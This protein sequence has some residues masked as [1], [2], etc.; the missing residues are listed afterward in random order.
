MHRYSIK[1]HQG[2]S[3]K[4]PCGSWEQAVKSLV[5]GLRIMAE[6]VSSGD[7]QPGPWCFWK[8]SIYWKLVTFIGV[9]GSPGY[10]WLHCSISVERI[11]Y[12]E[13][14]TLLSNDRVSRLYVVVERLTSVGQNLS[15]YPRRL[16]TRWAW[17]PMRPYSAWISL[18][19]RNC[20]TSFPCIWRCAGPEKMS[21]F[22][23][24]LQ[25]C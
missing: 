8:F 17:K 9:S 19:S 21:W 23:L 18:T 25:I 1:K 7:R 13:L 2:N 4:N 15:D 22:M 12:A 10:P 5:P 20:K 11:A 16:W 3:K 14:H 6:P 24:F